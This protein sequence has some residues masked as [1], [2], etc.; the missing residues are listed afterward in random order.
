MATITLPEAATIYRNGYWVA[1]GCESLPLPLA[2][3][4][5]D[6]AVNCGVTRAKRWLN[7]SNDPKEIIRAR[8]EH[9]YRISASNP[10]L[11]KFMRGWLNRIN[12]LHKY[13]DILN[14]TNLVA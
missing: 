14:E 1:S 8:R 10:S 12:D 11:K 3:V 5:F 6:T 13:S 2:V 9:Y 4:V 7:E